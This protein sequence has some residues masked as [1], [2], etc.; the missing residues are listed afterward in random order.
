MPS[1]GKLHLCLSFFSLEWLLQFYG[2]GA[3]D[4]KGWYSIIEIIKY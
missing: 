4:V 3:E 1:G 2:D